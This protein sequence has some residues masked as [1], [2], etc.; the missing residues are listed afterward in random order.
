MSR[1]GANL[2]IDPLMLPELPGNVLGLGLVRFGAG[3]DIADFLD[4]RAAVLV[5]YDIAVPL[6]WLWCRRPPVLE[7]T[8]PSG[9]VRKKPLPGEGGAVG[10]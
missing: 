6:V 8:R 4:Q 7:P 10:F 9:G 3:Q 5:T 2:R 1:N